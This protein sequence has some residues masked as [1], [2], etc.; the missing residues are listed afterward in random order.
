[1]NALRTVLYTSAC[2]ALASLALAGCGSPVVGLEC[3]DGYTRCG[4]A[5]Y[6]LTSDST[7]CGACYNDCGE[8]HYC[9]ASMCMEGTFAPD[10]A[11]I[12][13]GDGSV[14]DGST[15]D[16]GVGDGSVGDGSVDSGGNGDGGPAVGDA[17]DDMDASRDGG[18]DA[19]RDAS[20]MDARTGGDGSVRIPDGA[21]VLSDGAIILADGAVFDPGG[22]DGG[23]GSVG[24]PDG[25][26]VLS[27]GAIILADG[28]V[29]DPGGDGGGII[30]PPACD[31]GQR[32][33]NGVCVNVD[34]DHENCGSCGNACMVSEVCSAGVCAPLCTPPLVFCAGQCVDIT[35]D[36]ANCNG[37]GNACGAAAACILN[38]TSGLG[39]CVGQAVGHVVVVGHDLSVLT[40]PIRQIVGNTVFLAKHNPVRVLVYDAATSV[41]SRVGVSSAIQ[42]SSAAIGR[43]YSLTTA[44]PLL[45]TEQLGDADVFVI[46]TQQGASDLALSA[47]GAGWSPALHTFLFRGGVILLFDGGTSSNAGTYQILAAAT[48][49]AP[50]TD[51]ALFVASGR[52]LLSQRILN[53]VAPGDATGISVPT[54]YQSQGE[55]V[56]F[57]DVPMGAGTG[58][59]LVIQ[60]MLSLT[61]TVPAMPLVP[62]HLPVVIHNVTPH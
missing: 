60:D 49:A 62:A 27:D 41:P 13:R 9:G 58:T 11:I 53:L 20:D 55:T 30:V 17:G 51:P 29:F 2:V 10:G 7:N 14:G 50:S 34:T 28:A 36:D 57:S 52:E 35:S 18:R 43:A 56:G 40:R 59:T 8:G 54:Q 46:E 19:G 5:C 47:L 44:D 24:I 31:L 38:T 21:V 61:P 15:T 12:H 3:L 32:E 23:G 25:A 37:C 26:V 45:V 39:E 6:D 42:Q 16:G 48:P 4:S 22:N 33:C 1:M